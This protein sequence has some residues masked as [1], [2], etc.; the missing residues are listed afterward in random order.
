LDEA[1]RD[2]VLEQLQI[3]EMRKFVSEGCGGA[4]PGEEFIL[5]SGKALTDP[6]CLGLERVIFH[7]VLETLLEGGTDGERHAI[8]A[9]METEVYT[10]FRQ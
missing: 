5:L 7:E 8:I 3:V 2:K 4:Y 1:V 10:H 6:R 9:P